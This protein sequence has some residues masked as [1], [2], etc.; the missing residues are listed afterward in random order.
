M[1]TPGQSIQEKQWDVLI[2]R[3]LSP[4]LVAVLMTAIFVMES[5]RAVLN[6]PPQPLIV[7]VIALCAVTYAGWRVK[8]A[9]PELRALKLALA[10]EKIVG[11]LLET[12]RKDGYAVFHDVI[13]N[14]FNVDHVLIGPAGV[15]TIETKTRSKAVKGDSRVIFDGQ[16]LTVAG[17]QPDR[18]PIVQ[19]RA[20]AAWIA[21][22]LAE[23]TGRKYLVR[24]VVVFPG[25]WVEQKSASTNQIWVLNEKALPKFLAHEPRR[26]SEDDVSLASFHL[27][28]F[29]RSSS[30]S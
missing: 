1:R 8:N 10:G 6:T 24:P 15:L 20:Q 30:A 29:I 17:F 23:S 19:A 27:S 11:Q 13:G 2:D 18:D 4:I 12:L 14:G 26:L 16:Q 9:L 25:W 5:V 7:G 22:L 28:R 21:E 3:L